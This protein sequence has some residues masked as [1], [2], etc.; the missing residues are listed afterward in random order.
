MKE[1][2]TYS[3]TAKERKARRAAAQNN[4]RKGEEA[5]IPTDYS[6]VRAE[7]EGA[8]IASQKQ[9]KS[10]A[11][12]VGAVIAVAIILILAAILVPVISFLVNPYRNYKNVIARFNLSNGMV[13]EF[14]IDE[15]KYDIAATNFIFL[16]NNG[17]FD[18]TVFF[19]AQNGYIRFGGYEDQPRLASSSSDYENTRHHAQNK[20]Y[21]SDFS[22]LPTERFRNGDVSYKFG[23]KLNADKDGEIDS[24]IHQ[25]GVLTYLYNDTSTEF[26]MSYS[27]MPVDTVDRR[28]SGGGTS[29]STLK[30]TMVGYAL[31]GPDGAT[32]NNLLEIAK[33]AV[34]RSNVT[35][36]YMWKPPAPTIYIS[37]VKVYNLDSA[38]WRD[39]NFI[40]YMMSNGADGK[41]RVNYYTGLITS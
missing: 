24:I 13:L 19:D 10:T 31:D 37:S 32:V 9:S 38:K 29:T 15:E 27:D 4:A 39:F 41:R 8:M 14:V 6:S 28:D 33:L 11:I 30:P 34:D 16:A 26:Q 20:T 1:K 7:Q 35:Y 25:I 17:Y 21:C 18:N 3:L 2:R 23:Y 40:D 5:K 22:A 12:I 36:G